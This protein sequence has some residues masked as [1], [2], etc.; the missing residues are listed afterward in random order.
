VSKTVKV[1]TKPEAVA[2]ARGWI[3]TPVKHQ[4]RLRGIC[5]DCVA[6]I[7]EIARAIGL[8]GELPATYG[9][10]VGERELLKVLHKYCRRIDVSARDAADVGLFAWGDHPTH[11][12]LF[13]GF[14]TL[15]HAH[16]DPDGGQFVEVPLSGALARTLRAVFRYPGFES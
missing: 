7:D 8:V 9:R 13:T 6:P 16:A 10:S 4:G 11:V 3:G 15:V 2:M 5:G 12:G 14:N 1:I